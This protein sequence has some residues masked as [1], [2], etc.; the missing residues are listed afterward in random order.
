MTWLHSSKDCPI[1]FENCFIDDLLSFGEPSIG[2]EGAGDVR[3]IATVLS[4][5]VKETDHRQKRKEKI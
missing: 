5:H 3:G 2:R 1:G 4:P